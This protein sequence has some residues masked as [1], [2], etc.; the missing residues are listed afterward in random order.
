M[1]LTGPARARAR[2]LRAYPRYLYERLEELDSATAEVRA[3]SIL[4]GLGF[5][6]K[7][8]QMTTK[9][10]S[11]GWR[12]R[13]AL[14][15]AL[16]LQPTCLILDE[17]TN[18]LDM[19]AVFWLEDYLAS[20]KKILFFVSHSQVRARAVFC[21]FRSDGHGA[22]FVPIMTNTAASRANATRRTS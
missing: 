13:V 15:R 5:T 3:S 6:P 19:E 22:L 1:K 2:A 9:E 7:M 4:H 8:Q 11:G 18:H 14:A 21:G 10:F 12:M 16:F 17:P 20:W